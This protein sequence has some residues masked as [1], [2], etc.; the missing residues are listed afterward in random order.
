[1]IQ[2]IGDKLVPLIHNVMNTDFVVDVSDKATDNLNLV[3][4]TK[5][6]KEYLI[7]KLGLKNSL[8]NTLPEF[9]LSSIANIIASIKLAKYMNLGK[10][11]AIIT[12]ATDGAD[13]YLSE[14]EKTKNNYQGA[15]DN[16]ACSNIYK[17]Y[18]KKIDSDNM[19]ELS[20]N[21]KE[22][23]FN[24]GYYTWVEQQG[25]NLSDF[26]KRRDQQ[27]WLD[28]YNR[29]LSLDDRIEKFNTL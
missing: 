23:I 9:G 1:N 28:H 20:Q 8:V 14:L 22:R 15:F 16:A 18:L 25:V 3:F 2:G 26:E 4:N 13:L 12:V 10:E 29:M 27:F 5:I 7:N 21:D 24:L 17:K 6:G 11:D 19:L